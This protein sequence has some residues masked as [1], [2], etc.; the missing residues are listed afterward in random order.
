[1]WKPTHKSCCSDKKK[2]ADG[3]ITR[4]ISKN[5]LTYHIVR[6]MGGVTLSWQNSLALSFFLLL[7]IV[8]LIA[9]TKAILTAKLYPLFF[10]RFELKLS[11]N[12][13]SIL[14]CSLN[15]IMYQ[16]IAFSNGTDEIYL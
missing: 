8:V 4:F 11:K 9:D 12:P 7:R 13:P 10:R 6:L 3:G 5:L 2:V 14:C 16:L 15:L 1:V